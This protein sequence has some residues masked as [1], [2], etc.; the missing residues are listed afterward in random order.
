MRNPNGYGGITYLG[1]NRRNPFRV[2]ITTGWEYNENTGKHKQVFTTLGYYPTRKAAM[3]ALAKYNE[4][5]YDLD[6]AKITFEEIYVK[7]WAEKKQT[8]DK[9]SVGAYSSAYKKLEP[10]HKSKIIDLKKNELQDVMNTCSGYSEVLQSRV[11]TIMRGVFQYCLANDLVDKDYSQFVKITPKEGKSIH[12]PY[13]MNEVKLLWDNLKLGIPLSYSKK[14]I[15]DVYPVDLIL[16]MIYTGMRPGEVLKLKKENVFLEERYMIGGSKTDAGKERIIPIHEEIY[17]LVKA[18]Y[19]AAGEWLVPYKSDH[20]LTMT[21]Y[22]ERFFDPVL[23][24]LNLDHLPHDGRHTFASR[25]D[26]CKVN[27][28][29]IKRIMGHK[30]R[31]ITQDVYT[32]KEIEELIEAVNQITFV[33]E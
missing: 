24:R 6:K 14:D 4:S 25:A 27:I 32:H 21:Q 5:P 11:K 15:R 3:I 8:I 10:I 33:E 29:S 7:W 28:V 20:P 18:R 9:S 19:D 17:P 26:R 30:L 13:T 1:P 23:K 16:I 2:R 31:D 22:R 12:K